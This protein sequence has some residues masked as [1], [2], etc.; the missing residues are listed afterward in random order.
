MGL[1]WIYSTELTMP[2]WKMPIIFSKFFT[3]YSERFAKGTRKMRE[4]R[5]H[6]SHV[7]PKTYTAICLCEKNESTGIGSNIS[8]WHFG[9]FHLHSYRQQQIYCR[10]C[11]RICLIPYIWFLMRILDFG[12][13][14]PFGTA[15]AGERFAK[16]LRKGGSWELLFSTTFIYV[17]MLFI[18]YV[19]LFLI[20]IVCNVL[21]FQKWSNSH[22]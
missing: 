18:E 21:F 19:S 11:N 3:I 10:V 15:K 8:Q 2:G 6:S 1:Q 20:C 4:R 17:F 14:N 12:K 7:L 22:V 9:C 16:E 5:I 13:C